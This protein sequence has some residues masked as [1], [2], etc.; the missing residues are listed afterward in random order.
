MDGTIASE[1][2]FSGTAWPAAIHPS[3]YGNALMGALVA[4][5]VRKVTGKD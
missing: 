2:G 3:S 4:A 1:A 5:E